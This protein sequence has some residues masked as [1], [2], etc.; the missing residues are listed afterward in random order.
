MARFFRFAWVVAMFVVG[1]AAAQFAEPTGWEKARFGMSE[2]DLRAAV[3]GLKEISRMTAVGGLAGADYVTFEST[4]RTFAGIAD[5]RIQYRLFKNELYEIPIH[6]PVEQRE[7]VAAFLLKEYGPSRTN[8]EQAAMWIGKA[9]SVTFARVPG[10][11]SLYDTERARTAQTTLLMIS[12]GKRKT[13]GAEASPAVTPG[14][15]GK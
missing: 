7:K 12:L 15:E 1:P 11:V 5:C 6:C 13:P 4:G 8:S 3:P 10:V 9:G 14:A 2:A